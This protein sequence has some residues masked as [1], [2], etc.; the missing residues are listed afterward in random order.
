[1]GDKSA[2]E[3]YC[4][5]A[6]AGGADIMMQACRYMAKLSIGVSFKSPSA[7]GFL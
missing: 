1:M 6:E 2:T 4:G 3:P 7:S 5:H